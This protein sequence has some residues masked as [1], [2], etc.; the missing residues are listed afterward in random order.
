ME[1]WVTNPYYQYFCGETH[2]QHRPPVDPRSMTK[3]RDRLGEEGMEW[4]LTTAVENATRT[5]VVERSSFAHG[6]TGSTVMEKHIAHPTD[7]ALL[8]RMRARLVDF[9]REHGLTIRQSYARQ[10]L[11]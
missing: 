10:G 6:S 1:L 9:M 7:S 4:L 2:F 3:W 5:G 11:A 8:E